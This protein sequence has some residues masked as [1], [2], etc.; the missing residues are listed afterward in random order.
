MLVSA[1]MCCDTSLACTCI[2][3]RLFACAAADEVDALLLDLDR[4]LEMRNAATV[5]ERQSGE[6]TRLYSEA[7]MEYAAGMAYKLL[8]FSTERGCVGLANYV[9]PVA[10]ARVAAAPISGPDMLSLLHLAVRSGSM[11]MVRLKS[12]IR[13]GGHASSM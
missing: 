1:I 11:H 12:R 6:F 10:R 9:F 13:D 8:R 5:M 3:L 2:L 4:V 7:D